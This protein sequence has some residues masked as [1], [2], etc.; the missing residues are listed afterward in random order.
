MILRTIG[1]WA[2]LTGA[3]LTLLILIG[4]T[5][6]GGSDTLSLVVSEVSNLLLLIG[7]LAL[8]TMLA[9]T[10]RLGLI[11]LWCLGLGTGIALLVRF[12]LLLSTIDVGDVI[13][14]SRPCSGWWA[15]S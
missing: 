14:L 9:S 12:P 5:T 7:L 8:W 10:G 15:A 6:G 11:G 13:P 2:L 3:I 4:M 1:S